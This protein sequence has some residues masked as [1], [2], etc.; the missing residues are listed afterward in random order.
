[1][2]LKLQT[3]PRFNKSIDVYRRILKEQHTQWD[4]SSAIPF[5]LNPLHLRFML[6]QDGRDFDE[7]MQLY[8]IVITAKHMK[9]SVRFPL[10][11]RWAKYA[12]AAMHSSTSIAYKGAISLMQDFMTYAPT[13]EIQHFRLVSMRDDIEQLPLDYASYQVQT[14][15]LKEAVETLEQGRGLLW[16]ELRGMRTSIDELRRLDSRL[17]ER[18]AAVNGELESLTNSGPGSSVIHTHN[19]DVDGGKET[20]SFSRTVVKHQKLLDER[21][22]LITHI[23]SLPGFENF[24]VAPSFDQLHSS[25]S[26]G[27]V[28]IINH[29]HWRSDITVLYNSSP[30]LIPVPDNFHDRTEGLKDQLLAAR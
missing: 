7:I 18:F 25:A 8:P 22:N 16:S 27:P 11:C 24:L 26:H 2:H 30:S 13:L 20:N 14:C 3:T 12:R 15:Q 1:M 10:A 23:R 9:V 6:S 17:A 19:E 28:I 4:C 21:T 5:L 29:C